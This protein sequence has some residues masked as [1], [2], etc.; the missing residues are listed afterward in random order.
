MVNLP[1]MEVVVGENRQRR[2]F[3]EVA[4]EALAQDIVKHGLL[5]ALVLR[6]DKKTLV[7]G[8]RRLRAVKLLYARNQSFNYNGIAVPSGF[9]PC[10]TLAELSPL[11]LQEAEY[12]ENTIRVDLSWQEVALATKG[13]HALREAQREER[14]EKQTMGETATEIL[15][16]PAKPGESTILVRNN[17]LLADNLF[18]PEIAKAKTPKEAIKVLTKKKEKE[19]RELLADTVG[20]TSSKHALLLGD[21]RELMLDI[22]DESISVI[23]TDPPYGIG[24]DTFGDQAQGTHEYDDSLGEMIRLISVLASEGFRVTKKQAHLYCFCALRYFNTLSD[25]F[26]AQGWQVW[27]R[28]IIWS[29]GNGLLPVPDYGPRYT[30][31]TILFANKGMRPVNA[32]YSDVVDVHA[33][34]APKHA[35]EKPVGVYTNLLRRSANAGDTI[36]DPFCGGGTIF[37]A[38]DELNLI[39]I[40]F[41]KNKAAFGLALERRS[42]ESKLPAQDAWGYKQQVTLE[43]LNGLFHTSS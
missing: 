1:I 37:P 16:R 15:G 33:V 5:H 6:N 18:D 2:T 43:D 35:A 40:G 13:L 22:P 17:I 4:L 32:V 34:T 36:L 20:E 11:E 38:A 27:P 9:I 8:E 31:E 24:A 25:I 10:T 14:G 28:P 39:A 19:L 12:A 30:Y 23:I 42:A 3:D 7:A 21:M 26:T 29:K 41:E